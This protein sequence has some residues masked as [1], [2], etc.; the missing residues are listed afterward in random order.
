ML[1]SH[2]IRL[3]YI[4]R[5]SVVHTCFV[6]GQNYSRGRV[7][8][9][10]EGIHAHT[11]ATTT[12]THSP[13][14]ITLRVVEQNNELYL[15]GNPSAASSSVV[16]ISAANSCSVEADGSGDDNDTHVCVIYLTPRGGQSS[17]PGFTPSGLWFSDTAC[18]VPSSRLVSCSTTLPCWEPK[19]I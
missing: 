14:H 5:N 2:Q 3:V 19:P 16:A 17:I 13:A 1:S 15:E 6:F 10:P 9:W 18:T 4:R 11:S 12:P 8:L 7:D